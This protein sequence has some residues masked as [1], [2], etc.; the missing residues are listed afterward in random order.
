MSGADEASVSLNSFYGRGAVKASRPQE[1]SSRQSATYLALVES[2]ASYQGRLS[3]DRDCGTSAAVAPAARS[4]VTS[5]FAPTVVPLCDM[6]GTRILLEGASGG[7]W[8]ANISE[9]GAPGITPTSIVLPSSR[10]RVLRQC[11]GDRLP[12]SD[13]E[14]AY[15]FSL[16]TGQPILTL[17]NYANGVEGLCLTPDGTMLFAFRSDQ[18]D[19]TSI[20]SLSEDQ[21][22]TFTLGA[23]KQPDDDCRT[24]AFSYRNGQRRLDSPENALVVPIPKL[25]ALHRVLIGCYGYVED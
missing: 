3:A 10:E 12:L 5:A 14:A 20:Y 24:T 19:F 6:T 1:R 23:A 21:A 8:I 15:V 17:H 18:T 7:I 25:P 22:R 4:R 2:G 9:D 13:D 16:R 11:A